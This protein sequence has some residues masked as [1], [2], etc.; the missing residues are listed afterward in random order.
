MSPTKEITG[1]CLC[2][3]VTIK[4]TPEKNIFDACHCS[5]CRKWGGGPALTI[6][7]GAGAKL[8]GEEFVSVYDSSEWAD[9]GF[10]K[11]CGTHLFYRLKNANFW[12]FSAGLF[13][14]T[15]NFKFHVQIFVDSK[16]PCYDFANKTEMMTEAEV[17]AKFASSSK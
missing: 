17:I 15:D 13:K 2:G 10:C 11:R 1:R 16:P 7:G 14:E 8:S 9:R 12:N 6:E 4:A 5:M 3:A